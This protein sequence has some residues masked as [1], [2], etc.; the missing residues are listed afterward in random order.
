MLKSSD[1]GNDEIRYG[2]KFMLVTQKYVGEDTF[3]IKNIAPKTWHYLETHSELLEKRASSIYQNRPLYS[4]FGVG[5]YSFSSW[6]IAIS[7]LYKNLSFKLVEPY[8][9]KLVVLD[10]T[11]YFLPF[12][13]EIEAEFV[14]KLLNSTPAQEFYDSMIFWSDK[15]P[16]TIEIL[17]R[18]DIHALSIELGCENEYLRFARLRKNNKNEAIQGQL[19]LGIS[20]QNT[21]YLTRQHQVSKKILNGDM[22]TN[23]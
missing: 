13:S 21:H 16:I 23:L 2:R 15:R 14:L 20:E 1:I 4:I 11:T 12:W 10:D 22:D 7:G 19:S 6:K 9:E 3:Q 8:Q 18:L 5:D 17:K